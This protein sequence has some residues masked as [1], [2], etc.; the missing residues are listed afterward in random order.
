MNLRT[1]TLQRLLLIIAGGLA[2]GYFA[3]LQPIAHNVGSEGANLAELRERLDR[4]TLEA[5]L[6][7]ATSFAALDRRLEELR[8]A[9]D[10]FSAAVHESLPRLE[11][12][13]EVRIRLDEPFQLYSF[14]NE[15]QRRLDE[16]AALAVARKATVTP[17]LAAGL[18]AYKPELARPELLW[19]QLATVNR[20]VRSAILAGL[21][22]VREVSVEPLPLADPADFG[23]A[24]PPAAA[25][26]NGTTNRWTVIRVHLTAL[27]DVDAIGKL[28]LALTLTPDE[29]KKTGLP[30]ELGSRPALFVDRLLLRRNQL[31]AAEQAQLDLVVGT[32]I[33]NEEP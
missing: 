22:E 25:P 14:L 17:G 8:A 19:V 4:A 2:I 20:L 24:L 9:T 13:Q 18:P 31:E 3:L 29:L 16:I 10:A 15:S 26:T 11:L 1:A 12:P 23:P 7:R 21:R 30:D 6:P 27:G 5:G 33:A 32:V 28:L